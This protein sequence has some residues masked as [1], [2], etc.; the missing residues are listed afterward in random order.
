[1]ENE[2]VGLKKK[3]IKRKE[4]WNLKMLS[5]LWDEK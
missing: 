4:Q 1:M 2:N 5:G 3:A